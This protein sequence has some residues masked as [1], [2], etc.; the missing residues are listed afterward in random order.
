M[1]YYLRLVGHGIIEKYWLFLFWKF[2]AGNRWL[3]FYT[4]YDHQICSRIY[5]GYSFSIYRNGKHLRWKVVENLKFLVIISILHW[6]FSYIFRFE[7]EA[8]SC[9]QFR[10][11]N[12]TWMRQ[13]DV[14]FGFFPK[15]ILDLLFFHNMWKGE[16]SRQ[17]EPTLKAMLVNSGFLCGYSWNRWNDH[18][19]R[20]FP[21]PMD[22]TA[23]FSLS[24]CGIAIKSSKFGTHTQGIWII[25]YRS[26]V[27]FFVLKR[28]FQG[29][30]R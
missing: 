27:V 5:L 8:H 10:S 14:D 24:L 28:N 26:I 17:F 6:I 1:L 23:Y 20:V 25:N 11:V 9:S 12:I 29:S 30:A 2:D 18:F 22:S 19:K 16:N 21:Y 3:F 15:T 4:F 13:D 7:I